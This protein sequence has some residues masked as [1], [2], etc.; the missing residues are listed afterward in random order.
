MNQ[1]S[2]SNPLPQVMATPWLI[3]R[4]KPF[5]LS[6]SLRHPNNVHN[7]ENLP[8]FNGIMLFP[9]I[10]WDVWTMYIILMLSSNFLPKP[11][12]RLTQGFKVSL[13]IVSNP[14][15]ICKNLSLINIKW[16]ENRD[17]KLDFCWET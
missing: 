16:Q 12:E 14:F 5:D 2:T 15:Q 17:A 13:I 9:M 3:E 11:Q 4:H 1:G 6:P 7:I 8:K 10:L